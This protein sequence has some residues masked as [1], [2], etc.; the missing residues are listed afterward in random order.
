MAGG[1]DRALQERERVREE[2][3]RRMEEE[4]KAFEDK[5]KSRKARMAGAFN[6]DGEEEETVRPFVRPPLQVPVLERSPSS[7]SGIVP[8]EPE[9]SLQEAGLMVAG[10]DRN[11]LEE[12]RQI[13]ANSYKFPVQESDRR[14]RA[15]PPRR[16]RSRSRRRRGGVV[17]AAGGRAEPRVGRRREGG[18]LRSPT[19]D[20]IARGRARAVNKA[21]MMAAMLGKR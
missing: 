21:K 5:E 20:G 8:Y 9:G 10:G 18:S 3:R 19:P 1:L 11:V 12:A 16:S 4:K 7:S 17:A 15:S 13:L 6:F 14:G 2:G